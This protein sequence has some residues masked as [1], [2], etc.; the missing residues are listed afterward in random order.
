MPPNVHVVYK[1]NLT[2]HSVQSEKV[3]IILVIQ[4]S[5]VVRSLLVG[6]ANGAQ[7]QEGVA[8]YGQ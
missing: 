1:A 6:D 2:A 4:I 5:I 3:S 8:I 7:Y